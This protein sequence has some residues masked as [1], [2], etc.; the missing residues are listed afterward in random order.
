MKTVSYGRNHR[1]HGKEDCENERGKE[2]T[3][4]FVL[5]TSE[6]KSRV[7]TSEPAHIFH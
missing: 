7:H 6:F 4:K 3:R 5:K 2:K 1:R